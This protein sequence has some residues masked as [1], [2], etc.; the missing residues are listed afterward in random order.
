[1]SLFVGYFGTDR[2]FDDVKHH[3]IVLGERYKARA[4]GYTR[5]VRLSEHRIG[6]GSPKAILELVDNN[7]LA[8][9]LASADDDE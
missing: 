1:M 7:V 6:D 4:G 9:Q 2:K 8:Q 3:T 5:V